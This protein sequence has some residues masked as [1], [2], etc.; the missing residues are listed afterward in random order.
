MINDRDLNE[1]GVLW[2]YFNFSKDLFYKKLD[3]YLDKDLYSLYELRDS[4]TKSFKRLLKVVQGDNIE[5]QFKK[6]SGIVLKELNFKIFQ[7]EITKND[8]I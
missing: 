7:K 1:I 5:N 3:E 8:G 6:F 2:T 4:K